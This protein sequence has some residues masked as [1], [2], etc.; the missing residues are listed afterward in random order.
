MHN[1]CLAACGHGITGQY[2]SAGF[3]SLLMLV[4]RT[5]SLSGWKFAGKRVAHLQELDVTRHASLPVC[6]WPACPAQEARGDLASLIDLLLAQSGVWASMTLSSFQLSV[7]WLKACLGYLYWTSLG[8]LCYLPPPFF[9]SLF[10]VFWD[11]CCG[12]GILGAWVTSF[13]RFSCTVSG[14]A[15][16]VGETV[17]CTVL[18]T[19]ILSP[20]GCTRLRVLSSPAKGCGLVFF[21]LPG[22][23]LGRFVFKWRWKPSLLYNTCHFLGTLRS[24]LEC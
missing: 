21:Q 5:W 9:L 4:Q 12:K 19:H 8:A 18:L 16:E 14:E 11:G 7:L 15:G 3:Y 10:F 17:S 23:F 13:L 20:A 22:W 2:V 1:P 24:I 6:P